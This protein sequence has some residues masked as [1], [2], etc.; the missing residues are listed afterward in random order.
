MMADL[1]AAASPADPGV[2]A[3]P[4]EVRGANPTEVRTALPACMFA[5]LNQLLCFGM[6]HIKNFT[7]NISSL[8]ECCE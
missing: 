7:D 5:V 6:L 1:S 3:N 2:G 4:T 8:C